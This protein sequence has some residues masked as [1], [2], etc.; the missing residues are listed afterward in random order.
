MS[1]VFYRG[2]VVDIINSVSGLTLRNKNIEDYKSLANSENLKSFP[3]NT[4][5][6][7]QITDGASKT[8]DSE[9]ICY[10]FF[11]SHLCLP[12]KP[13]ECVWFIYENTD[14]KGSV[15]YW[16]SRTTEPGHAED[17]NHTLFARSFRQAAKK[18]ELT[19]AERF[20]GESNTS[21]I[22]QTFSYI[23]PTG[24]AEEIIDTMSF[25]SQVCRLESVPRYNKRPGDL[26][27]QG[28]NNSLIMLGEE[29]GH[30]AESASN[31]I[32]SANQADINS[33]LPAIDIVVGRGKF[34]ATSGAQILNELGFPEQDK[35]SDP[36]TE[37]DAHFPTDASRL[38]LTANSS[39]VNSDFHPDVLLNISSPKTVDPLGR[40]DLQQL[41][42]ILGRRA[43]SFFVGK[44]DNLRLIARKS[45]DVRI[46]KEPTFGS[47][48]GAA[49][50]LHS[51]GSLQL[52]GKKI[53]L[54]SYNSKDGATEPYVR[55]TELI[56]LMK[57]M[58]DDYASIA[59]DINDFCTSFSSAVP[60]IATLTTATGQVTNGTPL[61]TQL[62]AAA[63]K[64]QGKAKALKTTAEKKKENLDSDS[65]GI[66]ST[67]IFG[68]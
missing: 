47:I 19:T 9:V 58:I 60:Q 25:A 34:V 28:S 27:I 10:P 53:S 42:G 20:N 11:S 30:Y 61:V 56:N 57:S 8:N 23:S 45:G 31:I 17:V 13:G 43:G 15:A 22:T 63:G 59:S 36:P 52:C 49:V 18:Q 65:F 2:M 4:A 44:A 3:R 32:S 54:T 55:Y 67:I 26:V 64:L 50:I 29:R 24:D 12:L 1:T 21:A 6:V 35:R 37:G 68:E 39:N 40:L 66:K 14:H 46:I 33:G 16:L 62:T 7:K 51:S 38:Y 5:I 41:D 48:D